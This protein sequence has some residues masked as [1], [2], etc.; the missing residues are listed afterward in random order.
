MLGA[1]ASPVHAASVCKAQKSALSAEKKKEKS[2][3]KAFTDVQKLVAKLDREKEVQLQRVQRAEERKDRAVIREKEKAAKV[4]DKYD[5]QGLNLAARGAELTAQAAA[6]LGSG[7]LNGLLGTN[8]ECSAS[9]R[10]QLL[11]EAAQLSVAAGKAFQRRDSE[12]DRGER[13]VASV[14]RTFARKITTEQQK[15]NRIVD[16]LARETAKLPALEARAAAANTALEAA[17]ASLDQCLAIN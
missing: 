14:E 15:Y 8:L 13:R 7:V 9:A 4:V 17:Q 12:M 6:C 2:A 3:R 11:A 5:N 10:N 1:V 16:R